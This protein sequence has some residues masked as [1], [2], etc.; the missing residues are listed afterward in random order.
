MV[1]RCFGRKAAGLLVMQGVTDDGSEPQEHIA[2]CLKVLSH[3]TTT[4]CCPPPPCPAELGAVDEGLRQRMHAMFPAAGSASGDGDQ[5]RLPS[6]HAVIVEL[7]GRFITEITHTAALF[8][9]LFPP[10]GRKRL[11]KV[12]QRWGEMLAASAW[13]LLWLA[14]W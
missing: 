2:G 13:T 5:Q 3:L 11:V 12:R 4:P 10:G 14:G 9:E 1:L 8:A 7:D 6:L